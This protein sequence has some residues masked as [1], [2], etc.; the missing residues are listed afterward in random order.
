M[1]PTGWRAGGERAE[2]SEVSASLR[3]EGSETTEESR[4]AASHPREG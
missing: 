3:A 1:E 2:R 4:Q